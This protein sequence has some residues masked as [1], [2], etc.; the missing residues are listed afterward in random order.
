VPVVW[1]DRPV[2]A[3][4]LVC[5][6]DLA[7]DAFEHHVELLEVL[8]ETFQTKH[9]ELLAL[10]AGGPGAHAEALPAAGS[11]QG[12]THSQ[13]RNALE[14]IEAHLADPKLSVAGIAADLRI[15]STY[16]SHLF[17]EQVGVRMGR[18]IVQRRIEL[19]KKLLTTNSWQIKR[20][21]YE[22]G[23]KNADWFSQVFHAHVGM[24]PGEYR[25]SAR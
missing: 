1:R 4:K 24:T 10:V 13:V 19:A 17:A 5:S 18:Y 11:P 15:N 3:C 20:V 22:S 25:R 12:V 6:G 14:Y 9:G 21:A 8:I 7:A 2:A 16:L 23:H